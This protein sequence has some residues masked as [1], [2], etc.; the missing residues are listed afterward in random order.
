M[1]NRPSAVVRPAIPAGDPFGL[2]KMG[3]DELEVFCRD[4][5]VSI[6]SREDCGELH[7]AAGA[8]LEQMDREGRKWAAFYSRPDIAAACAK[9]RAK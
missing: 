3:D 8:Q 5:Y 7:A 6:L 2:K 4:L 9:N 1:V